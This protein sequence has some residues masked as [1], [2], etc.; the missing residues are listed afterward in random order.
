MGQGAAWPGTDAGC[1]QFQ[2]L[3]GF[4][5]Q[6][7][8]EEVEAA[9]A[10]QGHDG[11]NLP[12]HLQHAAVVVGGEE[13]PHRGEAL[14]PCDRLVHLP[15]ARRRQQP[16]LRQGHRPQRWWV[17]RREV[18]LRPFGS[19]GSRSPPPPAV[20]VA[21]ACWAVCLSRI[22]WRFSGRASRLRIQVCRPW[23]TLA[24]TM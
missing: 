22:C 17:A 15:V 6:G 16:Q 14:Q 20:A 21:V 23:K 2:Q 9:V 11:V 8:V 1:G 24:T 5:P 10:T 13:A 7:L 3:V 19:K 4:G 12:F 18:H